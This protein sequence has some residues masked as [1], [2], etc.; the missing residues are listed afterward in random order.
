MSTNSW[1]AGEAVLRG[2]FPQQLE[3]PELLAPGKVTPVN[4]E[5]PDVNHTRLSWT[6]HHGASAFM[7]SGL[8]DLNW[9]TFVNIPDASPD[10]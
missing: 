3:H 10:F 7:V 1:F 8:V 5:M 9:Q 4:F 2:K 6:P